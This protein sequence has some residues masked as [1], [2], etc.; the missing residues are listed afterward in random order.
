MNI[1]KISIALALIS[2]S[3]LASCSNQ[4]NID[5]ITQQNDKLNEKLSALN[6]K[7]DTQT[8]KINVLNNKVNQLNRNVDKNQKIFKSNTSLASQKKETRAIGNTT[9]TLKLDNK[10]ILGQ[11]EWVW[12]RDIKTYL[13]ARVDSGAKT[14]SL[15]ALN[16]TTFERDGKDWVSFNVMKNIATSKIEAP[17][18]RWVKIK[19]SSASGKQRRPVID[20]WIQIGD[21]KEK[22]EFTLTNRSHLE[23]P[24]LLGR[25]YI[26]DIAVVDVS[27]KF[28][29]PKITEAK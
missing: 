16:L 9:K 2:S 14:S 22:V 27:K 25:Q 28:I 10:I 8:T 18:A 3:I 12:L 13:K 4:S 26:K 24:M 20:L 5:Q 17:V 23:F 7:I 11:V 21:S 6:S 15:N 29:Q 19:Q 1:N